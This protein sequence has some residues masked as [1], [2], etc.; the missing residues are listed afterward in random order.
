M[1]S[2]PRIVSSIPNDLRQFLEKTREYLTQVNGDRFVTLRELIRGRIVS[3]TPNGEIIPLLPEDGVFEPPTPPTN[4]TTAGGLAAIL[5]SW[6]PPQYL[7]HS[8]TEI[9]ASETDDIATAVI[10]GTSPGVSFSHSVGSAATRYYWIRFVNI[11]E[12]F[13]PFNDTAGTIGQTGTDPAYLVGLL[14]GQITESELAVELNTRINTLEDEYEILQA[15]VS[16]LLATPEYDNAATYTEGQIVQYDGGLYQ[17]I[18]ETTGNLPTDTDYWL[19]IGDF[20]SLGEAVALHTTQINTL[21]SELGAETSARETLATQMRGGYTGT[22]LTQ[23]T[24]GLIFSEREARSTAVAAEASSRNVLAAQI[25]G[26][27]TGSDLSQLTSGLIWSE[28]IARTSADS[29]IAQS[30]TNLTTTVNGQTATIQTNTASINGVRAQH[31]VKIDNNG[32]VSGYG[33]LS[34]LTDGKPAFSEFITNVN[35]FAITVPDTS[36]FNRSNNISYAVGQYTKIVG[37]TDRMLIC[38]VAGTS[39]N[40][41][42]TFGAVGTTTTDGTVLWQVV[43]P[44]PES[45]VLLRSN[46]ASYAV[47]EYAKIS[48]ITNRM[49]ICR[50]P[51]VSGATVP[52]IGSVGSLVIDGAVTWQVVD[53]VPEVSIPTRTNST[54]YTVGRIAKVT[55]VND[56]I[57]ICKVAGTTGTTTPS[58]GAIGDL[59]VDGTVTWQVASK[60]PF[61]VLTTPAEISGATLDPGVYIDGAS[62][63]NATITNAQIN[64]A[65]I[66]IANITGTLTANRISAGALDVGAYIQSS[67]YTTG[68]QGW[69]INADGSAEFQNATVRGT[70]FATNGQF[71]GT[72][73]GRDATAYGTGIGF[74]SGGTSTD[75]RWRVG[76][77]AG[78][79]IQWNGSAVEVYN[80]SNQ[81]TLTSGGVDASFVSGLG[82]FATL[83]QIT[84]ANAS[85]YI[86]SAAIGNAQ[87][88]TAAITSAK[89][90]DLEVGTLKIAGNAVTQAVTA[91]NS[92]DL[93]FPNA[94]TEY[95]V[96]NTATLSVP[97]NS[98]GIQITFSFPFYNNLNSAKMVSFYIIR[99]ATSIIPNG[100]IDSFSVIFR[101]NV[102]LVITRTIIDLT[103]GTSAYYSVTLLPDENMS[104]N[105]SLNANRGILIAELFKR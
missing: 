99:N 15:E 104:T 67:V 91:K 31:T 84:S 57:L 77:P 54:S 78:A 7:G 3:T 50:V 61:A 44:V 9:W 24:S 96:V 64:L 34:T 29:A 88:G 65:T 45:T 92:S 18:A 51:G 60:V 36:I 10:I 72:L 1:R 23:V 66:D 93:Y 5:L 87:I 68:N 25:R 42:P 76:N 37:V 58:V 4:L 83:N 100:A 49:L 20:S 12:D 98:S 26:N 56:R 8:R 52:S 97:S 90:A 81:L 30:V 22:D 39:G 38:R 55:N 21:T 47:G 11:N 6:D 48:G 46:S 35:R 74:F 69:R 16:E 13:G 71:L 86:S 80:A 59:I 27:Y 62:I 73:L 28:R 75:Y 101:P 63:V 95:L 103:P 85:T 94:G 89:I 70:V 53:P 2:L 33:L 43:D 82:A 14:A 32:Y 79:R 40:F 102:D 19:K 17:A 41:A 105:L